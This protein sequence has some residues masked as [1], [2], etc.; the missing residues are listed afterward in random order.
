MKRH[1]FTVAER[2]LQLAGRVR[3]RLH[4][5]NRLGATTSFVFSNVR[6]RMSRT[7]A[8]EFLKEFSRDNQLLGP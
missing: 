7:N 4:F 1:F 2:Q 8:Q 3:G 6:S 5:G